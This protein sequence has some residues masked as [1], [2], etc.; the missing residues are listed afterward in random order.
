MMKVKWAAAVAILALAV[1]AIGYTA[2]GDALARNARLGDWREAQVR[3]ACVSALERPERDPLMS[4][5][6]VAEH[7]ID[8]RDSTRMI[9]LTAA[10]NCYVVT[11][12][13]AV[14]DRNNRAHI[15]DQIGKYFAHMDG[16]LA[17]ASHYGEAEVRLVARLWYSP[18][19]QAIAA[20]LQD[21]IR[22]GRLA[23]AD[24]GW[25]APKALAPALTRHAN[26]ADACSREAGPAPAGKQG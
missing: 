17:T 25:S 12:R 4:K 2:F 22:Q 15:V 11:N 7:H 10:L 21:H 5:F 20:A 19:H 1:P 26:A 23:K 6:P 3:G 13:N 24:F 16:M 18:R 9:E 14:C 8:L